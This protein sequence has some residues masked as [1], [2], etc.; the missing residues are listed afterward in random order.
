MLAS[1][2]PEGLKAEKAT[3]N[4]DRT[5]AQILDAA[6]QEF[7]ELGI[8]GARIERIAERAGTNKRMVYY[9]FNSKD[10]LFVAVMEN[11][12]A[13]IR[14]AEREL[15]LESQSPVD[16]IRTLVSF[17]WNYYLEHPEFIGLLNTEN[18]HHGVHV[19]NSV[20]FQSLNMPL[21][22]TLGEVIRQG[23]KEKIFRSGVDPVQLYIS[24]ASLSYFYL[25]NKHTLGHIFSRDLTSAK[26]KVERLHH[27]LDV[28]LGYLVVN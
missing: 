25:S 16:A 10:D 6:T 23:Q 5:R 1:D 13:S 22:E 17:T 20:Q 26:A 3:R 21:I 18:A 11:T 24:I 14:S 27:V 4:A 28:V 12:Y 19:K 15:H 7:A 2:A 8:A 9:Y